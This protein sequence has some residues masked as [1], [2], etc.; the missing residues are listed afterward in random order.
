MLRFGRFQLS[1]TSTAVDG[2]GKSWSPSGR[3]SWTLERDL[4]SKLSCDLAPPL[5]LLRLASVVCRGCSITVNVSVVDIAAALYSKS[6]TDQLLDNRRVRYRRKWCR[7][8][9]DFAIA[10]HRKRDFEPLNLDYPTLTSY[11]N[12]RLAKEVFASLPSMLYTNHCTTSCCIMPGLRPGAVID[13]RPL[14]MP[15]QRRFSAYS[16]NRQ[17]ITP[18]VLHHITC[19]FPTLQPRTPFSKFIHTA[20]RLATMS[21]HSEACCT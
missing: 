4:S 7:S 11:I 21:K 15:W 5:G 14:R 12:D 13:V 18:S 9:A 6:A 19:R 1:S 10:D 17:Y 3:W 2:G 8:G 16:V 20:S